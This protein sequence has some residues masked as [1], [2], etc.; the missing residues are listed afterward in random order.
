MTVTGVLVTCFWKRGFLSGL[1]PASRRQPRV[2]EQSCHRGA[3]GT[4]HRA[5]QG[6]DPPPIGTGLLASLGARGP[7]THP[8]PVLLGGGFS[9][10]Q[11]Q[12]GDSG[13]LALLAATETVAPE[14]DRSTP[15]G[16]LIFYGTEAFTGPAETLGEGHG[17]C[18]PCSCTSDL[19][20]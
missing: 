9:L 6:R 13:V 16:H 18:M 15:A 10:Q 1:N 5:H 8:G 17:G 7:T 11:G 2:C 14:A 20:P 12:C 4:G 3:Q 19:G